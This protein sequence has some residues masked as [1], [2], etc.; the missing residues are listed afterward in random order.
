MGHTVRISSEGAEGLEKEEI[1]ELS[2]EMNMEV[3]GEMGCKDKEIKFYTFNNGKPSEVFTRRG[4]WCWDRYG[5]KVN[6]GRKVWAV[7]WVET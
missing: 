2:R 6:F 3:V 7:V 1:R 4:E 5:F